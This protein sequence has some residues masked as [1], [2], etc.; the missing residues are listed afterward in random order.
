M[1]IAIWIWLFVRIWHTPPATL[2][3]AALREAHRRSILPPTA[4]LRLTDAELPSAPAAAPTPRTSTPS[5]S[6]SPPQPDEAS[7]RA[8]ALAARE[9]VAKD[10]ALLDA[11]VSRLNTLDRDIAAR[12]DPAQRAKLVSERRQAIAE[13]DKLTG[14][15]AAGEQALNG[16]LEDA[17][18]AGVPPGWL[19]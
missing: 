15:L 8:K 9:A 5:A 17:R 19:R 7:W 14:K 16:L 2:G 11:V 13:R 12:D 18:K 3:E 1:N 4:T 6:A 10:R